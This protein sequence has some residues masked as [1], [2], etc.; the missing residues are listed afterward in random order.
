[1]KEHL[2]VQIYKMNNE[3]QKKNCNNSKTYADRSLLRGRNEKLRQV[4]IDVTD[5]SIQKTDLGSHMEWS[6]LIK[7]ALPKVILWS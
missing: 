3:F 6:N 7:F 5:T 1:M 4:G 2:N